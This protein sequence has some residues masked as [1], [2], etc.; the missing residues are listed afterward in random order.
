M[1]ITKGQW[2]V[3]GGDKYATIQSRN[4]DEKI[5]VTYPTIATVNSTFIDFEEF[6]ANAKLIASAPELLKAC[7]SLINDF[8]T[9]YMLDGEIVDNPSNL[10]IVNYQIAKEAVKS[11]LGS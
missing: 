9:D 6:R 11:A 1:S 7:Q 5:V 3:S 2:Y 8:E 10:L 4:M